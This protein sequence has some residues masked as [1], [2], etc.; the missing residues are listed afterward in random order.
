MELVVNILSMNVFQ[1]LAPIA[2]FVKMELMRLRAHV[3]TDFLE[4]LVK[5]LQLPVPLCL[6]NMELPVITMG[7]LISVAVHPDILVPIAKIQLI[8]VILI[9]ARTMHHVIQPQLTTLVIALEPDIR[10]PHV[11]I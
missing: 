8:I 4:L 5:Q 2:E 10:A 11:Q 6:A 7:H 3:S 9:L 1:I